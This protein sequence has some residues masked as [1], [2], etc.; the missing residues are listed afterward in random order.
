MVSFRPSLYNIIAFAT[1]G[2]TE[3]YKA[4]SASFPYALHLRCFRHY[5]ANL[6]SKLKDLGIS[7]GVVKI[8]LTDIFRRTEDQGH[9]EGIVDAKDSQDFQQR[10]EGLR[11][12]GFSEIRM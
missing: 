10:S 2:K 5:R 1:D 4:F 3:L 9:K 7:V 11:D 8:F 12:L 6:N